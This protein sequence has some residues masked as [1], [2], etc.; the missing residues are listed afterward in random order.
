MT[1]YVATEG[2]FAKALAARTF[3]V[4]YYD[5]AG[6]SDVTRKKRKVVYTCPSCK[7]KLWG[8]PEVQ[9]HCGKCNLVA[10]LALYDTNKIATA[11]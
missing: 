3:V 1:H 7:D 9:P 2:P 8:K 5:R 10:M 6:E 4:P 11:A